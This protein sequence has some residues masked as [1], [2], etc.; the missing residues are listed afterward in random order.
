M[1]FELQTET[2]KVVK[3]LNSWSQW[4]ISFGLIL[5]IVFYIVRDCQISVNVS[6]F[7]FIC[8]SFGP[9]K[10]QFAFAFAF[11]FQE[12]GSATVLLCADS[13]KIWF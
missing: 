8:F 9:F 11:G 12:T 7:L 5:V 6:Q 3:T 2:L 13:E 1:N 10:E 4:C